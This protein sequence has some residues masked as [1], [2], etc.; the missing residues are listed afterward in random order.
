MLIAKVLP[1]TTI[2]LGQACDAGTVATK[3]G[4]KVQLTG[5]GEVCVDATNRIFTTPCYMLNSD[6]A[7]VARGIAALVEK[8]LAS[9]K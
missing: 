8:L 7:G 2:T 1:H 4:A 9:L 6:I 3:L 5:E